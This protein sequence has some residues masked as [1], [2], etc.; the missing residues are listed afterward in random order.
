MSTELPFT[1]RHCCDMTEKLLKATNRNKQEPYMY[2]SFTLSNISYEA[3]GLI[4]TTFHVYPPW[5]G[6]TY[7]CT[8]GPGNTTKIAATP[9]YGK[10]PLK[11][12]S[13]TKRPMTLKHRIQHQGLSPNKVYANVDPGLT[14]TFINARSNLLSKAFVWE[15]VKTVDFIETRASAQKG[16]NTPGRCHF[17]MYKN[18]LS[19]T[20]I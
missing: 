19:L 16:T 3:I 13:R 1:T 20:M 10:N 7:V 18:N 12:F 2:H 17:L 4:E 15:N 14:L 6:G 9:I 5:A 8:Y 11:I